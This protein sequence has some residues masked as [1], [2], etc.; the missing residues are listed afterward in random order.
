[1]KA[2]SNHHEDEVQLKLTPWFPGHV[3]PARP[4]VY[5]QRSGGTG[6]HVGYQKW[7]GAH[8]LQW[9]ET[10]EK[11]EKVPFYWKAGSFYQNDPWRGVAK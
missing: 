8:W 9:C 11:A 5:Q 6:A 10:A 2:T 1:M 4:G 3:K 7:T